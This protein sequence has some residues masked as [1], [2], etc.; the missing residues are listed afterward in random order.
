[1]RADTIQITTTD[2]DRTTGTRRTITR[3]VVIETKSRDRGKTRGMASWL[4]PPE[5]KSIGGT[6][7]LCATRQLTEMTAGDRTD[8]VAAM[9]Q[10]MRRTALP[11]EFPNTSD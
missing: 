1:M 2:R 6:T 4:P 3:S 10:A 11:Q 5:V 7:N 8:T 9:L